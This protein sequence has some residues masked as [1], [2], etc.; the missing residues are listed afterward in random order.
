MKRR[1]FL[2]VLLGGA[3][4]LGPPL[5]WLAERVLPARCS[6][7]LRA[8]WYP[9]PVVELDVDAAGKPGRWAG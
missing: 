5:W 9:G 4:A 8:R 2:E 7:A 3:A 6:E 1:R